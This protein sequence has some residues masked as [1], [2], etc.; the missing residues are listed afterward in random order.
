MVINFTEDEVEV[1]PLLRTL[2]FLLSLPEILD[3]L[4]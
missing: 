2:S 1:R 3:L 4:L